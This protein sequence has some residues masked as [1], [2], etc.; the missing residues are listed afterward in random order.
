MIKIPA[1]HDTDSGSSPKTGIF[2]KEVIDVYIFQ[3]SSEIPVLEYI[4]ILEFDF[5]LVSFFE[6]KCP[7]R[8]NATHIPI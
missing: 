1:D 8:L 3:N 2:K 4:H 5:T 6:K 7:S